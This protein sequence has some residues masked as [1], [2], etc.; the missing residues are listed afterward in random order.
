MTSLRQALSSSIGRKLLLAV[1]GSLMALFLVGHLA[2]NLLVFLGP[3]TFNQ[4]SH[5]LI[6]N[7]LLIPIEIGLIVILLTHVV[8]AIAITRANRRARPTAYA[9][10]QSAG[11]K[12]RKTLASST[13]I[14]SGLFLLL[15][16]PI[17]IWGLKFG[18][19]YASATDPAVRDL[20][21][22]V[23]E[24]FSRPGWVAFYVATMLVLGFHLRHGVASA[25][26]SVGASHPQLTPKVLAVGRL[27]AWV[28]AVGF[29]VIPLAILFSGSRS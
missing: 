26:Q 11:G 17:H 7:P 6:S 12:S 4:Y 24:Y 1:T 28:I 13:M 20:H 15:F 22:L 5:Q 10:K 2:G 23:F 14:Y 16:V 29:A 19:I 25:F 27:F 9:R 18:P 21:R 8:T 3:E